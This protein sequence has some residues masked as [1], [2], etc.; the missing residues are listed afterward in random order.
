MQGHSF[1]KY[2]ESYHE[3]KNIISMMHALDWLLPRWMEK[4]FD[5]STSRPVRRYTQVHNG[6]N[7]SEK[8]IKEV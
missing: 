5:Q 2:S 3:E 6:I 8:K 7:Q 4:F 1:L